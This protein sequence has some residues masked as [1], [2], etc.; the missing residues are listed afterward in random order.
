M[1]FWVVLLSVSLCSMAVVSAQVEPVS[2]TDQPHKVE[3]KVDFSTVVEPEP[4]EGA[5]QYKVHPDVLESS[6]N[7]RLCVTPRG[8]VE[9]GAPMQKYGYST[10]VI[11]YTTTEFL[12]G[13][14]ER[15]APEHTATFD[16]LEEFARYYRPKDT[17]G[18][19]GVNVYQETYKNDSRKQ[20]LVF[21]MSCT[22][23]K[24]VVVVT[25]S[26][27]EKVKRTDLGILSIKRSGEKMCRYRAIVAEKPTEADDWYAWDN[28]DDHGSDPLTHLEGAL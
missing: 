18:V 23:E 10:T 21:A 4:E 22:T 3:T 15:C 2:D 12:Y 25:L 20:R 9:E 16:S 6:C 13:G 5:A 26:L 1:K 28:L 11:E 14:P 17:V 24:G 19:C 27:P 8:E 7:R